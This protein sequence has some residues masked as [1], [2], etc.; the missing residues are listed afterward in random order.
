MFLPAEMRLHEA[1]VQNGW[2]WIILQQHFLPFI[3][4]KLEEIRR[5]LSV[6][7]ILKEKRLSALRRVVA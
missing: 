3:G 7:R 2:E 6:V 5:A 1:A 4:F